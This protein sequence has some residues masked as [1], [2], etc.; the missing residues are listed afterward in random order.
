MKAAKGQPQ[1]IKLRLR[2]QLRVNACGITGVCTVRGARL[3]ES[4]ANASKKLISVFSC[5]QPP[6]AASHLSSA[7]L[8]AA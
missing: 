2:S 6:P 3:R 8:D 5:L 4:Q 7:Q 1:R